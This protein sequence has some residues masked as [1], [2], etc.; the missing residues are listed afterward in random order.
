MPLTAISGDLTRNHRVDDDAEAIEHL[1]AD[2]HRAG[3]INP[4]TLRSLPDGYRI[5]AGARRVA[6]ARSLGWDT[7][8]A[9]VREL[10]DAAEAGVRMSEN[11]L[12]K[13]L[14][15][16]EE[17]LAIAAWMKESDI[18]VDEAAHKMG[19]R[20]EWVAGRLSIQA[21]H[22][23]VMEALHQAVITLGVAAA[24]AEVDDEPRLLQML[25]YISR[26]GANKGIV[27]L[28]VDQW[29]HERESESYQPGEVT[30]PDRTYA[31]VIPMTTCAVCANSVRLSEASQISLC[32]QCVGIMQEVGRTVRDG[33]GGEAVGGPGGD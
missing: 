16:V 13:G 15:P 28:W 2:I 24:L 18:G 8:A 23:V 27:E 6:A 31:P 11:L 3:L 1:A 14:S 32:G 33:V 17:A 22:P 26:T 7:I 12:Q 25:H 4:I 19:R 20:R 29:R 9:V 30:E 21:Y 10:D 5:V